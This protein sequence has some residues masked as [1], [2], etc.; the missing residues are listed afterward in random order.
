MIAPSSTTAEAPPSPRDTYD[1]DLR[2][3][4]LSAFPETPGCEPE[5]VVANWARAYLMRPHPGLGRAGAVCPFTPASARLDAMLVGSSPARDVEAIFQAMES[6]LAA[7]DAIV[8]PPGQRHFRAVIVAFPHCG[9]E[10]G[11]ARLKTVQNRLRPVS[12]YRG[13][14]IGLFEPLS[15]D[16]GLINPDFRPLRSPVPLLAIRML[17]ENDA[18]FVLRNPRLAPI[19][20]LK[21]PLN[22][23]LRLWSALWR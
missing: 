6:A 9:G 15:E 17:V 7:F 19:Y 12:I 4:P 1:E 14:M 23:P 2:L 3:R 10:A 13:K 5:R 8:C 11:R 21:F 22:G 20:L 18:P 16:K